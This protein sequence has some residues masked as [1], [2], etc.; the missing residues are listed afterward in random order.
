VE[1]KHANVEQHK[2]QQKTASSMHG[3]SKSTGGIEAAAPC[4]RDE[5]HGLAS[6]IVE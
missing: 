4:M 5:E 1:A 2:Q 3:S 6:T